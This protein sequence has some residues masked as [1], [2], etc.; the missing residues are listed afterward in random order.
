MLKLAVVQY[1][2]YNT[3]RGKIG[4]LAGK[5]IQKSGPVQNA[6]L[7]V[8]PSKKWAG[9]INKT[10]EFG[11]DSSAIASYDRFYKDYR[12]IKGNNRVIFYSPKYGETFGWKEI[13][14]A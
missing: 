6:V 11:E 2:E 1:N 12:F 10:V 14:L 8:K 13:A 5:I 3:S 9:L 7:R 4:H